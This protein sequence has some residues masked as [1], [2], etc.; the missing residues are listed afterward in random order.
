MVALIIVL[1]TITF[2]PPA[3]AAGES[4]REDWSNGL[5]AWV[6]TGD[7]P[8]TQCAATCVLRVGPSPSHDQR[9]DHTLSPAGTGRYAL[10]FQFW[11]DV[12]DS[13]T[14]VSVGFLLDHG[15]LRFHPTEFVTVNDGLT[16][17]GDKVNDVGFGFYKPRQWVDLRMIVDMD[18]HLA[19][20]QMHLANGLS[21]PSLIIPFDSTATQIN[22]VYVLGQSWTTRTSSFSVGLL[23]AGPTTDCFDPTGAL[24]A[25]DQAPLQQVLDVKLTVSKVCDTADSLIQFGDGAIQQLGATVNTTVQHA[26]DT[27]GAFQVQLQSTAPTGDIVLVNHTINVYDPNA[28]ASAP[29]APASV[30]A[31]PDYNVVGLSWNDGW[32]GGSAITSH[33]VYR[34]ANGGPESLIASGVSGTQYADYS[35]SSTST[36]QYRVTSVNGVGESLPSDA[37]GATMPGASVPAA[38]SVSATYREPN[39]VLSWSDAASASAVAS[40]SVYRGT[41]P[42]QETLLASG[43]TGTGYT[44]SALVRGTTYY[45]RVAAI[46]SMGSSD[47]STEL[48]V[49]VPAAVVPAA[50]TIRSLTHTATSASL[51]WADGANGG[52]SITGHS[53]YRG[54]APGTETLLASGMAGT[55]FTDTTVQR[56]VTY[57]YTVTATN[58]V[59]ESAPSVESNA[60][61]GSTAVAKQQGASGTFLFGANGGDFGGAQ[62][63]TLVKTTQPGERLRM[64]WSR[65]GVMGVRMSDANGKVLGECMAPVGASTLTCAAVPGARQVEVIGTGVDVPWRLAFDYVDWV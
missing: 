35:V 52:S 5:G 43:V 58:G 27:V 37:Q 48:S 61:P 4:F 6:V 59:G 29:G 9:L 1:G 12:L 2:A 56:N 42:G 11:S 60:T 16:L 24:D 3:K 64:A 31:A 15:E 22:D 41:A 57:Y 7:S 53:V 21:V 18:L 45:Y 47:L 40:H 32:N 33:N 19:Q 46:N 39:V 55:T 34:S 50:P 54:T 63:I 65:P 44:D 49:P 36:Y 26:F 8:T 20:A 38:P 28:P 25:L 30:L 13:D 17:Y 14:D 51:S 10:E 23:T 62:P